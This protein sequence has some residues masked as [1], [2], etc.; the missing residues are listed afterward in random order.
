M[1][2]KN[3]ICTTP[4]VAKVKRSRVNADT[5]D[6]AGE[7]LELQESPE[8]PGPTG[9]EAG[10][11]EPLSNKAPKK[12]KVSAIDAGSSEKKKPPPKKASSIVDDDMNIDADHAAKTVVPKAKRSR[13]NGAQESILH[14][15]LPDA[16]VC[17]GAEV[18]FREFNDAKITEILEDGYIRVEVPELGTYKVGPGKW[19][20]K[21]LH[22]EGA[23][24]VQGQDMCV[25]NFAEAGA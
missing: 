19:R 14:Y 12:Q 23:Q 10:K 6:N 8:G 2:S 15:T 11:A 5:V 17:V 21:A 18:V 4:K 3:A 16:N 22:E 1:E 20:L 9:D 25:Q 7:A 24:Q 13:A